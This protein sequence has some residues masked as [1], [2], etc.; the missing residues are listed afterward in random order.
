MISYKPVALSCRIISE[1]DCQRVMMSYKPVDLSFSMIAEKAC[2]RV[3]MSCKPVALSFY[4]IAEKGWHRVMMSCKPVDLS[5]SF[6][7][8]FRR[9]ARII[10]FVRR[11]TNSCT[12]V[13]FVVKIK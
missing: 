5:I 6:R 13:K 1:K 3:M 10:L 9:V 4:M 8:S 11:A 2:Q 7:P 12:F